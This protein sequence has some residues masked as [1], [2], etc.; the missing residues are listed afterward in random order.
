MGIF[1]FAFFSDYSILE[2]SSLALEIIIVTTIIVHPVA[3]VSTAEGITL[4]VATA[5][6]SL[7]VLLRAIV[8]EAGRSVLTMFIIANLLVES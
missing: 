3:I 4:L 5:A 7:L 6:S 1:F 8:V 2:A